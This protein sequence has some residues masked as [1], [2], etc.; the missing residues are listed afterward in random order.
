VFPCFEGSGIVSGKTSVHV[1]ELGDVPRDHAE[2][3]QEDAVVC[4]LPSSSA[5]EPVVA[6]SVVTVSAIVPASSVA[7]AQVIV[8]DSAFSHPPISVGEDAAPKDAADAPAREVLEAESNDLV[9]HEPD[10]EP[11]V[12]T[13]NEASPQSILDPN[14]TTPTTVRPLKAESSFASTVPDEDVDNNS[15]AGVAEMI[16]NGDAHTSDG[17]GDGSDGYVDDSVQPTQFIV[18]DEDTSTQAEVTEASTALASPSSS[19]RTFVDTGS[20][21]PSKAR[22]K[23]VTASANRLSISYA[24]GSRRLVI[25]AQVVDKL[26]VFRA[27]GRIEVHM[28]VVKDA[29][30]TYNGIFVRL[31]S[32][33]QQ[34]WPDY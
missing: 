12:T 28:N 23:G 19:A 6:A 5:V 27:E 10:N 16:E 24:G 11:K 29:T 20:V 9:T 3:A 33:S 18:E 31:F 15:E 32:E 21:S 13:A 34:S 14:I 4:E 7:E 17:N 8:E 30:G 26:K 2:S 22:G 25:N 1:H